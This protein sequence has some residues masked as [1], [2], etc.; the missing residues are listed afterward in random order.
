MHSFKGGTE[1][2]TWD[3]SWWQ[4]DRRRPLGEVLMGLVYA[5][6]LHFCV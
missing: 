4:T 1:E 6:F 2:N 3:Q 5:R